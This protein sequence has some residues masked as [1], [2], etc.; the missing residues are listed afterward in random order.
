MENIKTKLSN[1]QIQERIRIVK[2]IM[3]DE[4]PYHFAEKVHC[5]AATLSRLLN[6]VTTCSIST[7]LLVAIYAQRQ[8]ECTVTLEEFKQANGFPVEKD[9][10]LAD[11]VRGYYKTK[12]YLELHLGGMECT[13]CEE[14][15]LLEEGMLRFYWDYSVPELNWYIDSQEVL[16]HFKKKFELKLG[17]NDEYEALYDAVSRSFSMAEHTNQQAKFSVVVPYRKEY[18]RLAA[19]IVNYRVKNCVSI[20]YKSYQDG[21][22]NQME[23]TCCC[24]LEGK[25]YPS[26]LGEK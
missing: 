5:S 24:D 13:F 4:K 10:Y 18:E 22:I 16:I 9:L 23:E 7:E 15:A 19:Q 3:G 14:T 12:E 6:G 21:E 11:D 20:L 1:E 8:P 17:A 2:E 26:T 25:P